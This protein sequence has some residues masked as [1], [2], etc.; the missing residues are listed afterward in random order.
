MVARVHQ[1][2][3]M[4]LFKLPDF[5]ALRPGMNTLQG[6]PRLI[7]QLTPPDDE[8][9]S[10]IAYFAAHVYDQSLAPSFDLYSGYT[11]GGVGTL[12]TL[13][14]NPSAKGSPVAEVSRTLLPQERRYATT[15]GGVLLFSD[16]RLDPNPAPWL[17]IMP[18][19]ERGWDDQKRTLKFPLPAELRSGGGFDPSFDIVS[20][21]ILLTVRDDRR[22]S[23]YVYIAEVV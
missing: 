8:Y 4:L 17:Y 19:S 3:S 1:E 5:S 22:E 13:R 6:T 9:Q 10:H 7:A 15:G 23:L 11:S 2:T 12:V 21:R 18:I 20:G 14:V 16:S